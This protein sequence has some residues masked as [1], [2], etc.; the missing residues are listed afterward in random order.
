MSRKFLP[1]TMETSDIETEIAEIFCIHDMSVQNNQIWSYLPQF[2]NIFHYLEIS[3][4]FLPVALWSFS[5]QNRLTIRILNEL[6]TRQQKNII[7]IFFWWCYK[8]V[9]SNVY[10][11]APETK[12]T[13]CAWELRTLDIIFSGISH[14]HVAGVSMTYEVLIL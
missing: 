9:W 10:Q 2:L 3:M 6:L 7:K 5:C 4:K 13:L 12:M 1:Q 8:G 11:Y 14:Y